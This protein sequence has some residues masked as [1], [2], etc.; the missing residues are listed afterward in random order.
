[1]ARGDVAP[2]PPSLRV[3]RLLGRL[4]GLYPPFVGAGIRVRWTGKDPYTVVSSLKLRAWNRNL[5]GTHFGG[6]LYAMCDPFFALLLARHLG[7][8]Y[9][10][11]DRAASIEFLEPGRGTVTATFHVPPAEI[12]RIRGQADTG[13]K[14]EP[15]LVAEV[16]GEAG[17]LVA[18]VEK[19]LYVRKKPAVRI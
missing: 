12:E 10:V 15:L 11:W 13:A 9:V 4:L 17:Q 7:P 6:S 19:R 18:R 16:R 5:F 2:G 14:V 1:M 3:Q 8:G